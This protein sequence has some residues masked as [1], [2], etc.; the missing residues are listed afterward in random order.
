MSL[1]TTGAERMFSL[2]SVAS[3]SPT[4]SSID[5]VVT[6]L[7]ASPRYVLKNSPIVHRDSSARVVSNCSNTSRRRVER[8]RPRRVGGAR[9]ST[10]RRFD[11]LTGVPTNGSAFALALALALASPP[12]VAAAAS[13]GRFD[14][15][16]DAASVMAA[17]AWVCMSSR[18]SYRVWARGRKRAM[19]GQ[20]GTIAHDDA[21]AKRRGR[22]T[23]RR[24]RE[25]REE[26]ERRRRSSRVV[27]ASEKR[28]SRPRN[29]NDETNRVK[30]FL[31]RRRRRRRRRRAATPRVLCC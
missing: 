26:T 25:R 21:A 6:S 18:A 23:A 22:E 2:A 10:Y 20:R 27:G 29:R 15:G 13:F 11:A 8:P 12:A 19:G 17:A 24:R 31:S 16:G 3:A 28:S 9:G 14:D 4:V 30:T 1:S 5:S 7:G